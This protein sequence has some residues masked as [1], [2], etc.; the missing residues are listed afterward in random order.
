MSSID[1]NRLLGLQ[2]LLLKQQFHNQTSENLTIF[3]KERQP[4]PLQALTHMADLYQE[5]HI[6]ENKT[7][8]QHGSNKPFHNN[9]NNTNT[10]SPNS[11]SN[12]NTK[13]NVT[14]ETKH[15][16]TP[17]CTYC[18]KKGHTQDKCYTKNGRPSYN[19]KVGA[20]SNTT[21]STE[22]QSSTEIKTHNI[23]QQEELNT[24]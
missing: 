7:K 9:K 20:M 2:S 13:N 22:L 14:K 5:A 18:N 16:S 19:H 8:P 12:K 4:D 6:N 15:D 3:L 21:Y 1:P 10:S 17:V 11:E 23:R 24:S